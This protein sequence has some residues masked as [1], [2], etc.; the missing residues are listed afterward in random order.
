LDAE[1]CSNPTDKELHMDVI[2]LLIQRLYASKPAAG[3]NLWE[4]RVF[5]GH[6]KGLVIG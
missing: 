5:V 1:G 6:L 3:F 2:Q 4:W